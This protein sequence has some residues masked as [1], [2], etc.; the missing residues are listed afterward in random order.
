M[1]LHFYIYRSKPSLSQ[2][3]KLILRAW[4]LRYSAVKFQNIV[5]ALIIDYC[6]FLGEKDKYNFFTLDT[7]FGYLVY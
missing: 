4:L 5:Y 3:E 2:S 6:V 1:K 7:S